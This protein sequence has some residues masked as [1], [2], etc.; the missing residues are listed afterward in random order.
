M[1]RS[2]KFQIET[3][4]H[5]IAQAVKDNF[6]TTGHLRLKTERLDIIIGFN[7]LHGLISL[8]TNIQY[9]DSEWSL[10]YKDFRIIVK[11]FGN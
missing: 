9:L 11:E 1:Q 4:L 3:K 6:G 8:R 10:K 7:V 2:L 5:T